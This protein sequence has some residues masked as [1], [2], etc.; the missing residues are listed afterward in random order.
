[1]TLSYR[2][3]AFGRAKPKN[4]E[5]VRRAADAGRLRVLLNSKVLGIA[6]DRIE[7][8]TADGALVLDNDAVIV[9]AGGILPTDFLKSMGIDIATLRG[10]S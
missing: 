4:R 5:A 6:E 8:E 7:I 2:S 3:D 9:C 1:V 10:E